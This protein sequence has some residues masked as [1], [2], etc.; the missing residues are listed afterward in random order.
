MKIY[1]VFRSVEFVG[2]FWCAA[3]ST[4]DK[5]DTYI[6]EAGEEGYDVGDFYVSAYI[7]DSE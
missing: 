1:N 3:F 4:E 7:V 5:A 2:E 6:L